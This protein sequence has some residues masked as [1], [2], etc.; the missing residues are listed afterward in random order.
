MGA[1]VVLH[2]LTKYLN[3]YIGVTCGVLA[4]RR[5]FWEKSLKFR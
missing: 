4:A 3:G 2:G 5:S 1:D